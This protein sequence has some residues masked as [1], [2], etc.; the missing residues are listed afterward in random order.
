MAWIYLLIASVFEIAFATS[1]RLSENFSQIKPTIA[2]LIS[3]ILSLY[4]MSLSLKEIPIGTAYAIWTGI[5]GFGVALVGYFY[6]NEA[7]TLWRLFFL[8]SLI[9]SIVGLKLSY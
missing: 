2:F 3:S 6:F 5:G 4:F 8:C 9:I 1:L 7:L